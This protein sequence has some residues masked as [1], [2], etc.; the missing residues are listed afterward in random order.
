V[1][2]VNSPKDFMTGKKWIGERK[3]PDPVRLADPT[4]DLKTL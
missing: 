1:D 3:H 4:T 2:A